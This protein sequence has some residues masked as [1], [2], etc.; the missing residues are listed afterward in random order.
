MQK[1]RKLLQKIF[2]S[3]FQSIFKLIYGNI[4]YDTDNLESNKILIN[5]I[6]NQSI[7]NFFNKKYQIYKIK[8]GRIYTDNVE[9]VALI[10]ENKIIDNI[11]FQQ[12]SGNLV[13]A[14]NNVCIKKGTPRLKKFFK[15][16]VLSLAQ[17]ASGNFNYYHW[18]F[19][20][21]PKIKLYSEIYNLNDLDY[22]YA[23]K[24][25][26]WQKQ[27]LIPLGLDKINVID[28][29]KYRHIQADEIVCTDHPSYYNGYIQEQS[30]NIPIWVV[31]WLRE[32]FLNCAKK[33]TCNDK[34]FI[35]RSSSKTTHCQF[36]NNKEISNFLINKGFTKYKIENLNFFE[37]IYLF[38]NSSFVIGAHGAGLSNL[39]FCPKRIRVIEIRP[40]NHTNSLYGKLSEINDLDYNLISTNIVEE[41]NRLKGDIYLDIK[42]LNKFF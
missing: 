6:E 4:T 16:R 22:L 12:I 29:Q 25:K 32:T 8:K 17:G 35:D 28:T 41:S 33:F 15:G 37:E 10:S 26:N 14:K 19:D 18:L 34:I 21:L 9:N 42:E 27:S 5:K 40:K 36:I 39:T 30:Q 20:L 2:K 38:K 13:S 31:D 24:L 1:I 23:G 11:S 7:I 3:F